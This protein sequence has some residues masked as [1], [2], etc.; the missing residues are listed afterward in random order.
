MIKHP[1]PPFFDKDSTILILGSFPSVKSREQ[2]FFYGHPQNRFWKVVAAVFE[3]DVPTNIAEKK[4]FLKRNKIAMWDVIGAC[5]IEGSADSTIKDVV[6]NDL[7]RIINTA[8]IRAIFVNGKTAEKYYNRYTKNMTGRTAI[9]LPSTSPA[10]AAWS[11]EKLTD[12]WKIIKE[13][14]HDR[15]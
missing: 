10:N 13:I 9:C 5:E 6:P 7:L 1:I 8:H 14:P 4:D 2:M 3:Q 11:L 15:N 12:A